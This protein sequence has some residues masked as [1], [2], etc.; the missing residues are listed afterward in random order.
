MN[1]FAAVLFA[2]LLTVAIVAVGVLAFLG[3]GP[4][5]LGAYALAGA[6]AIVGLGLLWAVLGGLWKL[7]GWTNEREAAW[8][9]R[10]R[11][12]AG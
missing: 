2:N 4:A 12:A 1:L 11:E 8:R 3:G 10:R 5:A 6:A 9:K 7:A